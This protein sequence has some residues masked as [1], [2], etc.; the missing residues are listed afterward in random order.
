M[1]SLTSITVTRIDRVSSQG[2]LT[3]TNITGLLQSVTLESTTFVMEFVDSNGASSTCKVV[4]VYPRPVGTTIPDGGSLTVFYRA[5]CTSGVPA[6][7][8]GEVHHVV[9][10]R[11]GGSDTI[12]TTAGVGML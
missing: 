2:L 1:I 12:F 7:G 8:P 5:I 6:D 11:L 9:G 10:V 4:Y 3:I